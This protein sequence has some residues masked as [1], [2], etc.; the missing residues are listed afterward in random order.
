MLEMGASPQA[1]GSALAAVT[2]Q[3]LVRLVCRICRQPAPAPAAQTL[4]LHGIGAEEAAG[5][6]FHRGK[7]CPTCNS[8]GYRGRRAIFEVLTG[9]PEVRHSLQTQKAPA[10]I[11]ALA[12]AS[13]MTP[14]RTRCLDLV[15]SGMTSFDEFA[16]QRL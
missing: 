1:L 10:D 13:G 8:V 9:S 3:R 6:K 16:K 7:G 11:E 5:L 12:V 15:R 4:G 14:L 2:S